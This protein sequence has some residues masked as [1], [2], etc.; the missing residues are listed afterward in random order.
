MVKITASNFITTLVL[1]VP[2]LVYRMYPTMGLHLYK[3]IKNINVFSP[4][5][6]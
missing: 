2:N 6:K 1:K 3:M 4:N 5:I